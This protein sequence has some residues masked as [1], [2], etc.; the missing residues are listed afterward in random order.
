MF[1][2]SIPSQLRIIQKEEMCHRNGRKKNL[3]TILF[4]FQSSLKTCHAMHLTRC[5]V[6]IKRHHLKIILKPNLL[7]IY[8]NVQLV[9]DMACLQY[10]IN[11][12]RFPSIR[13]TCIV[14]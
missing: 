5:C 10:L 9:N 6:L 4:F 8:I 2:P 1:T 7:D 3:L 12:F 14:Y 11:D 13:I